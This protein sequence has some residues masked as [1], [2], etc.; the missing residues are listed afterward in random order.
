M[1][2]A[3][4]VMEQLEAVLDDL[5]PAAAKTGALGSAEV[6]RAIAAAAG[7]FDFPLVVDPVMISKHGA[8]LILDEARAAL[9]EDLCR[10]PTC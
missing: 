9:A 3:E 6:V 1:L 5:R 10:G 8:P 2:P 7:Q 4:L